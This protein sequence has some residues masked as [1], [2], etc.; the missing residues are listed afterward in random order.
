MNSQLQKK[1][2]HYLLKGL[3]KYQLNQKRLFKVKKMLNNTPY[4]KNK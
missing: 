1:K 2:S 4:Q 3:N